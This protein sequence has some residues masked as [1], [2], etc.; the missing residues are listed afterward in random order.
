[1]SKQYALVYSNGTE[2][3]HLRMYESGR[4]LVALNDAAGAYRGQKLLGNM[5]M[6]MNYVGS[7]LKDAS[8]SRWVAL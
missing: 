3:G 6:V 7:A 5:D 8:V 2:I 1:M 4:I